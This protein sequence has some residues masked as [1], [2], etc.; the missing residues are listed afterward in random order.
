MAIIFN[1]SLIKIVLNKMAS[2]S[3][4][5]C[6]IFLISLKN[7]KHDKCAKISTNHNYPEA[8]MVQFTVLLILVASQDKTYCAHQLNSHV[9]NHAAASVV[10]SIGL[11]ARASRWERVASVGTMVLLG[12]AA[13]RSRAAGKG[14]E[15]I[16]ATSAF[17]ARARKLP[18]CNRAVYIAVAALRSSPTQ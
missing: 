10:Y 6:P 1:D 17:A 12:Q 16:A 13:L 9:L 2:T 3:E 7:R 4:N 11:R 8:N 14:S 18:L 15:C 5:P